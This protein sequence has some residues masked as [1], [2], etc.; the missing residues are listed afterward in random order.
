M[1]IPFFLIISDKFYL[2]KS[3]NQETARYIYSLLRFVEGK[4][5]FFKIVS[6]LKEIVS[7]SYC[8]RYVLH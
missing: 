6:I 2:L 8:V 1:P 4:W 5:K 3:A 7:A